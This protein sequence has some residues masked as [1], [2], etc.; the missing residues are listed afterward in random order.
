MSLRRGRGE[1][2]GN[3]QTTLS[4]S[5]VCV[6]V[7]RRS[8]VFFGEGRGKGA[9]GFG[10]FESRPSFHQ[11]GG[12]QGPRSP[13][14]LTPGENSKTNKSTETEHACAREKLKTS[15]RERLKARAAVHARW[16][17]TF[18]H[19][20]PTLQNQRHFLRPCSCQCCEELRRL[21]VPDE[22]GHLPRRAVGRWFPSCVVPPP[23]QHHRDQL[24]LA[25]PCR[26]S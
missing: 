13:R 8:G 7:L 25:C 19:M 26:P 22:R 24:P 6:Q 12:T 5:S 17:S 4:Q 1:G 2:E 3:K 18:A 15:S 9:L 11:S 23:T 21:T 20:R 10:G 14:Q 16:R